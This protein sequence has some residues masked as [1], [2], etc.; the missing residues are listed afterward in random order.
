MAS[1]EANRLG[2]LESPALEGRTFV[3]PVDDFKIWYG[4]N[5]T[6]FRADIRE[7]EVVRD[8][9]FLIKGGEVRDD[10]YRL[11]GGEIVA[12]FVDYIAYYESI[13]GPT[14]FTCLPSYR[15]EMTIGEPSE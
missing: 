11:E 6:F 15:K 7:N 10:G 8:D 3:D 9:A 14:G 4:V 2:L 12:Q 1:I 5:K 13:D